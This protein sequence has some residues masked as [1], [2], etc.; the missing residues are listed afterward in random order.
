MTSSSAS[1]WRAVVEVLLVAWIYCGLFV[2][3]SSLSD[4]GLV[5]IPLWAVVIGDLAAGMVL[6]LLAVDLR[7][8]MI[9]V[10]VASLLA[11]VFYGLIVVTPAAAVRSIFDYLSGYGATQMVAV[12]FLSLFPGFIGAMIGTVINSSVRD[13]EL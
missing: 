13:Y 5:S 9:E 8:L 11:S 12:F 3:T 1:R 6:A 4:F 10:P 2:A 7:R